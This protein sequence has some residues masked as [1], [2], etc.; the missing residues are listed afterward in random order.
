MYR[1]NM[2]NVPLRFVVYIYCLT[3]FRDCIDY[4]H[5]VSE[6]GEWEGEWGGV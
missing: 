6:G 1:Y 3:N 2:D 4:L 5:Y